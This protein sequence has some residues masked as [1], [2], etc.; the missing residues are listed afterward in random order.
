MVRWAA[1]QASHDTAA[2]LQYQALNDVTGFGLQHQGSRLAYL[3]LSVR[4]LDSVARDF[5]VAVVLW[6]GPFQSGV[7]APNI[8]QLHAGRRTREL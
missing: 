3:G 4:L 7:E 1:V 6:W 5:C 2:L 8:N